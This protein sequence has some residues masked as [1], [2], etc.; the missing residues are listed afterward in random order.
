MTC[1]CSSCNTYTVFQKKN[2]H[3]T[4]GSESWIPLDLSCRRP[5]CRPGSPTGPQIFLGPWPGLRLFVRDQVADLVSRLFC[6][7]IRS[8]TKKVCTLVTDFFRSATSPLTF[9]E[10]VCSQHVEIDLA[11]PLPGRRFLLIESHSPDG[12]TQK[13]HPMVANNDELLCQ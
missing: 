9:S 3:Q 5:G 4:H 1:K 6:Q 10:K 13:C 2:R 11:G 7:G 12:A 8:A